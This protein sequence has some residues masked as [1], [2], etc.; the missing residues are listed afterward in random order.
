VDDKSVKLEV[1][2]TPKTETVGKEKPKITILAR[3]TS[4][5]DKTSTKNNPAASINSVEKVAKLDESVQNS[6]KQEESKSAH[7]V[8]EINIVN[9]YVKILKKGVKY[10][11]IYLKLVKIVSYRNQI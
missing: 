4:T 6:E 8:S 7:P 9:D 10:E 5:D 2:E 1:S 11:V 3:K